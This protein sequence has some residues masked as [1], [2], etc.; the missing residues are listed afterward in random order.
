ME[1]QLIARTLKAHSLFK[2]FF[3]GSFLLY[4]AYFLLLA[5]FA[6]TD[7]V[8]LSFNEEQLKGM[9]AILAAPCFALVFSLITSLFFWLMLAIGIKVYTRSNLISIKY[10]PVKHE[11]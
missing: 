5:I 1:K 4:F 10:V 6:H 3:L 2:Y 8:T 9:K 11:S 7:Y